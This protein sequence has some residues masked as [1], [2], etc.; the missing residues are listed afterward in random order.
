MGL[1]TLTG[2]APKPRRASLSNQSTSDLENLG[3][4]VFKIESIAS[5][6]VF[7]APD[8]PVFEALC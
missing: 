8:E 1:A 7:V 2:P 5:D 3:S 4:T 6:I